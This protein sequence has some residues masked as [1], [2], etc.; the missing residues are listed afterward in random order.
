MGHGD[1]LPFHTCT[2]HPANQVYSRIKEAME[3]AEEARLARDGVLSRHRELERENDNLQ[4]R[5]ANL[6]Q[7][8]RDQIWEWGYNQGMV[9]SIHRG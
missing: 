8:G 1:G 9:W 3:M 7:V 2:A 5:L 4:Q 6:R